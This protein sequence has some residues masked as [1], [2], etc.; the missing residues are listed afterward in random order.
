M[1]DFSTYKFHPSSLGVLMTNAQGKKDTKTVEEIGETA[2]SYLLECW[3]SEHYKREKDITNKYLEKGTLQ[4]EESITLYSRVTKRFYKKNTETI[5]ND[6]FIGTPDLY[7]GESILKALEVTDLKTSW[8]IF[9]FFAVFVK[10]INPKY[11]WQVNAYCDLTGA[12]IGRLAYCLVNTPDHLINDEKRRLAWQMGLIDAEANEEYCKKAAKIDFN[13]RFDDIPIQERY[14]E[15]SFPRNDDKIEQAH[16]RVPLWR[17]FL[18]RL[19]N[20]RKFV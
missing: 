5:Q 2:K 19:E 1:I 15:F 17:E 3:I 14:I 13:N 20:S 10:P 18:Q 16:L 7:D 11:E 4:E 8:D 6:Y 12:K 9:T